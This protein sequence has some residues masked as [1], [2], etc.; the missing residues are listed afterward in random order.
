[1]SYRASS[2]LNC[3]AWHSLIMFLNCILVH[4]KCIMFGGTF[5]FL[6][7]GD[8]KWNKTMMMCVSRIENS[9]RKK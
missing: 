1:M 6:S 5:F 2:D 9:A 8:I 7:S 4:F 3:S